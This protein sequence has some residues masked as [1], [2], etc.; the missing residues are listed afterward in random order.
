MQFVHFFLNTEFPVP[1]LCHRIV[2]KK[3]S[4]GSGRAVAAGNMEADA[5]L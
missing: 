1:W 3:N 2:D 5:S 4:R